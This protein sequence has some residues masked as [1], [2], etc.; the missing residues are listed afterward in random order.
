M[1]SIRILDI[2]P[3]CIGENLDLMHMCL[4]SVC[5]FNITK[6]L[7]EITKQIIFVLGK[8]HVRNTISVKV[9]FTHAIDG[10]LSTRTTHQPVA[11]VKQKIPM[12]ISQSEEANAC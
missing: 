9:L 8:A 6:Y 12:S 1:E 7:R 10:H 5:T 11:T 2:K 3:V 4:N